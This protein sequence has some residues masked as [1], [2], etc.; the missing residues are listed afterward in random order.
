[1]ER[2]NTYETLDGIEGVPKPY[3]RQDGSKA[4]AQL[5]PEE[6]EHVF[7]LWLGQAKE[8]FYF[9]VRGLQVATEGGSR[10]F[11]N[12]MAMFQRKV[13]EEMRPSIKQLRDGLMPFWRRWWK[14]RTKKAAKDADM[15]LMVIWLTAFPTRPFYGQIGAAN[16][17]QASIVKKR[18]EHLL[19][20]NKWL[21]EYMEVIQ[22]KIRSK[23]LMPDNR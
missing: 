7:N 2:K 3:L 15:A 23:A 12:V 11:E 10:C 5:T 13:F 20:W 9:F 22:W 6:E 21:N 18:I 19:Y 4:F 8:D 14:E 16:K 1:M 17:E